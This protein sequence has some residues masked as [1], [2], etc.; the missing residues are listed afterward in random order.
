[1]EQ[2]EFFNSMAYEWDTFCKH[3]REKIKIILNLL[4]IKE[5]SKVLDVG[6]GTGILIPYLSNYVGEKGKVIAIDIAEKMIEIAQSKYQFENVSFVC[7]DILE[8]DLPKDSFD[9]IIC[10][11][12]FPHFGDKLATIQSISRLLRNGGKFII[13]HSQ[14]RDAINNLHK[15][16]SEAVS[17]D[18]LPDMETIKNYFKQAGITTIHQIDNNE[19]FVIIGER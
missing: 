16:A 19:V 10:Y 11:S 1:M 8:V 3:D 2:K 7:G 6:T 13:C 5:G 14:S 9:Y 15:K 17:E 18:N 12:V 4:D